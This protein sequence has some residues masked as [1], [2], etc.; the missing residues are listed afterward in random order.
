[1]LEESRAFSLIH[2]KKQEWY[3]SLPKIARTQKHTNTKNKFRVS[4]ELVRVNVLPGTY[5]KELGGSCSIIIYYLNCSVELL[6][7]C[8]MD[9]C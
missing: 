9:R 6:L 4:R 1:M 2:G 5:T 3:K 7:M 8:R